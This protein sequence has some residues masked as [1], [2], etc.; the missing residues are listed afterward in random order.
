[1][2]AASKPTSYLI[3]LVSTI[4]NGKMERPPKLGL[5]TKF[6]SHLR[7]ERA[8]YPQP[9]ILTKKKPRMVSMNLGIVIK[10]HYF[11]LVLPPQRMLAQTLF[12]LSS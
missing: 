10:L 5:Q 6:G 7:K 12:M 8:I 4:P 11:P 3:K 1:M 9:K 2:M